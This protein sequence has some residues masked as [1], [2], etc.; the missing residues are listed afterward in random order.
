VPANFPAE[1][2]PPLPHTGPFTSKDQSKWNKANKFIGRGSAGSSTQ[3]YSEAIG[4]ERANTGT[5]T[6]DDVV[7]V[8]A[9]GRRTGRVEPDF[10]EIQ[11]AVDAGA[12]IIT[13]P[14]GSK[15]E[16]GTRSSYYN[17][18]ER[19]VADYLKSR[20]YREDRWN[21]GRW[22][23]PFTSAERADLR[24]QNELNR[25]RRLDQHLR[26]SES[27]DT[28]PRSDEER[29][30]RRLENEESAEISE[31]FI[32]SRGHRWYEEEHHDAL[33]WAARAD[34]DK[35]EIDILLN[36][37]KDATAAE[38]EEANRLL[39]LADEA[40]KAKVPTA[41]PK[42]GDV[43]REVIISPAET[44][45]R[46]SGEDPKNASIRRVLQGILDKRVEAGSSRAGYT[47][48]DIEQAIR[49]I[50]NAGQ[51]SPDRR[52]LADSII[53]EL[54]GLQAPVVS[55]VKEV[56]TETPKPGESVADLQRQYN[57]LWA[58]LRDTPE[59][60]KGPVREQI[61]ALGRRIQEAGGYKALPTK[62]STEGPINDFHQP[63]TRFLSNF[64]PAQVS[65]EGK[66]YK[67]VEHAYQAA[68]TTN[69]ADRLKIA[70][71][72][73][74][75]KAKRMVR[76]METRPDWDQVRVGI[77]ED[78]LHQKFENPGLKKMLLKTSGRELIEGNTWGD[79]F[80]GVSGGEGENQLGKL[81]MKVRD[82]KGVSPAGES[83]PELQ[84]QMN[85]LYKVLKAT[86]NSERQPIR[87][88]ISALGK[89][90]SATLRGETAVA[91]GGAAPVVSPATS[92]IKIVGTKDTYDIKGMRGPNGQT[93][94]TTRPE[95]YGK[96]DSG[97][98]GNP[99]KADDIV[100]GKGNVSREKAIELFRR[101]FLAKIDSDPAFKAA[102]EA[103][104]G[105][106]I[107]YYKPELPNHLDVVKE[108]LANPEALRKK[109]AGAVESIPELAQRFNT[110]SKSLRG[111][112][113]PTRK[114]A[115]NGQMNEIQA[116]IKTL[117][118]EQAISKVMSPETIKVT[119]QEAL[120]R[121]SELLN[122]LGK[123]KDKP[124]GGNQLLRDVLG[125]QIR[126][127]SAQTLEKKTEYL[128]PKNLITSTKKI[129]PITVSKPP[130][131]GE[132]EVMSPEMADNLLKDQAASAVLKDMLATVEV[133]GKDVQA[134]GKVVTVASVRNALVKWYGVKNLGREIGE[135]PE[136]IASYIKTA[137]QLER[138]YEWFKQ[139]LISKSSREMI[140]NSLEKI[141]RDFP[142]STPE[143]LK[144]VKAVL[145][146]F[147]S[148]INFKLESDPDIE[149]LGTFYFA[150]NI[151]KLRDPV[152]LGH[153]MGHWG[154]Y[155][156]LTGKE[157]LEVIS[158]ILKKYPTLQSRQAMIARDLPYFSRSMSE[159]F[160]EQFS[161][162]LITNKLPRQT[163]GPVMAAM[164]KMLERIKAFS[165]R[166]LHDNLV[167]PEMKPYFEKIL[168]TPNPKAE[169]Q[170]DLEAFVAKFPGTIAEHLKPYY[171]DKE[172]TKRLLDE[173]TITLNF[174]EGSGL[175]GYR[176]ID[177]ND[178]FE[179]W[180]I[181][182]FND[183]EVLRT[184]ML[185]DLVEHEITRGLAWFHNLKDDVD[186]EEVIANLTK[187]ADPHNLN[188][189][190][191]ILQ[192]LGR[193][194][195]T[196][197]ELEMLQQYG[198]NS[199]KREEYK[200]TRSIVAGIKKEWEASWE[201]LRTRQIALRDA[202]DSGDIDPLG[203]DRLKADVKEALNNYKN[204]RKIFLSNE[205]KLQR[206]GDETP[207]TRV[208]KLLKMTQKDIDFLVHQSDRELKDILQMNQHALDFVETLRVT[209]APPVDSSPPLGV[210]AHMQLVDEKTGKLTTDAN[211][212]GRF[213]PVA[214]HAM[215]G[216]TW[217]DDPDGVGWPGMNGKTLR[218]DPTTWATRFGFTI[219]WLNIQLPGIGPL[220]AGHG[221]KI[222]GHSPY[223]WLAK[224]QKSAT[225]ALGKKIEANY[226]KLDNFLSRF[227]PNEGLAPDTHEA[228]IKYINDK[229]DIR[230]K[231]EVFASDIAKVFNDKERIQIA[232]AVER[233]GGWENFSA[234]IKA[235]ADQVRK[236]NESLYHLFLQ[237]GVPKDKLDEVG[238][239]NYLHRIYTRKMKELDT[240]KS[241]EKLWNSMWGNVLKPRGLPRT[242]KENDTATKQIATTLGGLEHLRK[243]DIVHEF[244]EREADNVVARYFVHESNKKLVKEMLANKTYQA[245]HKWKVMNVDARP[246]KARIEARRDYSMLERE[247]LG[248][249]KDVSFRLAAFAR[250]VNHDIALGTFFETMGKRN[251]QVFDVEA[252]KKQLESINA[253]DIDKMVEDKIADLKNLKYTEVPDQD[254]WG[255][256]IKRYGALTNKW[257]DPDVMRAM[258]AVTLDRSAW[259]VD[260]FKITRAWRDLTRM[261]KIGKTAFNPATHG[262]NW[263]A[264]V[265]MCI[266]DGR[267]PIEVL[268]KGAMLMA[269]KGPV[270]EL[271]QLHGSSLGLSTRA[272]YDLDAFMKEFGK[273]G[274]NHLNVQEMSEGIMH[275]FGRHTLDQVKE[276]GAKV[277]R[278]YEI[279]DEI[280]KLGVFKQGI[281]A[282]MQ[283]KEAM[284]A[285]N[286]LFFDYRDI[287]SGI[288]AVRDWGIAPFITYT[289]K[290]LP[291]V[292]GSL[293]DHPERA[294]GLLGAISAFNNFM[295][296][297]ENGENAKAVEA[298]EREL[299]PK[300]GSGRIW[301]IG[302][303]GAVKMRSSEGGR[304]NFLDTTR[305]VPLGD[306][307]EGGGLL[308]NYPV[309]FHPLISIVYGLWAGKDPAFEKKFAYSEPND[310]IMTKEQAYEYVKDRV[311]F[312]ERTLLPNFPGIPGTYNTDKIMDSLV[313]E[314]LIPKDV[315][316]KIGWTGKDYFGG[317]LN[318][319]EAVLGMFG[320]KVRRLYPEREMYFKIKMLEAQ[321]IAS[322]NKMKRMQADAR[323]TPTE[324]QQRAQAHASLMKSVGEEMQ[325]LGTL[326]GEAQRGRE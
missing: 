259:S 55:P 323:T 64:H 8:S 291:V 70:N 154:F 165:W 133:V 78:L 97:W 298:Y 229:I 50:D 280:F 287:P 286:R 135:T 225:A 148:D 184:E 170:P 188:I 265:S 80:W 269:K 76:K 249:V 53:S 198:K 111:V 143:Q 25:I 103:L 218:W 163:S 117:R 238:V 82:A 60:E 276:V 196:D 300:W 284:A 303:K 290:A 277:M 84:M 305:W 186:I 206:L 177:P 48:E 293:R 179:M 93:M 149:N 74:P 4:P 193:M 215:L 228:V 129:V 283:P 40:Q 261:W 247:M 132:A 185:H 65:Y 200:Q 79:K 37:S 100:G 313:A 202:Q 174:K 105:K 138:L 171:R 159:F 98:L 115:I 2:K 278:T 42:S 315:A 32:K 30:R 187:W 236:M 156:I 145:E 244:V 167:V 209:G 301:G 281:D 285:A 308:G 222:K 43:N 116:R 309:S 270:Y 160:A 318:V 20:G 173:G 89:R 279:G 12:T 108:Y 5:Y 271:A 62:P 13:D 220:I 22:Y 71:A 267:S 67:T 152:A 24:R 260:R 27:R 114:A 35:K 168:G 139:P 29:M 120:K 23:S 250:Q 172:G 125:K 112:L 246:G 44:N 205:K 289:Y 87:D 38:R 66:T 26:V 128:I 140:Q 18:G 21:G 47:K 130:R 131:Y 234:S 121:G 147:Q 56:P 233:E 227:S 294:L 83:I 54:R 221:V 325:R 262:Y 109:L 295:Y 258:K 190:A 248:E 169:P 176:V 107:G 192:D 41:P 189:R 1:E 144:A 51:Q 158:D 34:H 126:D 219:P 197:I 232:E 106:K 101:D 118:G 310:K 296:T 324:M 211:K 14:M 242:F 307:F 77:M 137:T 288:Q 322:Q 201:N 68:K 223:G 19:Q 110:L 175:T 16:S 204:I 123:E 49:E 161:Q 254:V 11:R 58:K 217:E 226:P 72:E 136:E 316:E 306:M 91:P 45:K 73:T 146:V 155:T 36:I 178:G 113:D 153:E 272:E 297:N 69:E 166:L 212:W 183:P 207:E 142:H 33:K 17:E 195:Q 214:L 99:H 224:G 3:K 264:N 312:I 210:A 31:R 241:S 240:F 61:S 199:Q 314:G 157:R 95:D 317:K 9:E 239:E 320:A 252:Y 237:A 268:Y 92:T 321:V 275:A 151:I 203:V 282:G 46:F 208:E 180:R 292:A 257:V 150:N 253:K 102:V 90:I 181:R 164:V 96:P 162:Y 122:M 85:E 124:G 59:A 319:P 194:H 7:F 235:Q 311:L 104:R 10:E 231:I 245:E 75:G 57:E 127:I 63:E 274:G 230:K 299:Q 88:Q 263:I 15:G 182:N 302:P 273:I 304:S 243:N 81:L 266:F 216:L 326:T 191:K 119:R 251:S 39:K 134:V 141:T 52:K 28:A 255:T 213:G 6:K 86:P 256:G 94:A